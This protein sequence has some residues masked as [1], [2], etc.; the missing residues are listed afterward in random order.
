MIEWLKRATERPIVISHAPMNERE[1]AGAFRVPD[2]N[3]LWRAIHQIIGEEL[4]QVRSVATQSVKDHGILAS[5][6]GGMEALERLR[7]RLIDE[8]ARATGREAKE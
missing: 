7:A 3:P 5:W 6:V 8:R 2:N 1:L 4:R